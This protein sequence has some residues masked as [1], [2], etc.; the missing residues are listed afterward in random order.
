MKFTI[1]IPA[2]NSSKFINIPLDSLLKQ[3]FK[4]F[5]VLIIDDG[6]TDDLKGSVSKYTS[7]NKNWRVIKK[8]NGNWGSVINYVKHKKL[9]KGDYVTVLD[10]DDFFQ[11]EM[12]EEVSKQNGDIITTSIF[13]L[14]NG[15][16]KKLSV[17]FQKSGPVKKERSFT[18]ISTPHGKFYN[19]D[20]FYSMID[21]KEG[22]S[23]QDTV[24]YHDMA[25]KAKSHYYIN[26]QLATWWDDRDGNSSTAAWDRKRADIWIETCERI[27]TLENSHPESKSWIYMYL[28][29]MNKNY[30]GETKKLVINKKGAKFKW[31]PLGSR[32]IMSLYFKM[33]TK[34]YTNNK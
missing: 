22:I 34:K 8:K 4:D 32:T 9:A 14:N 12:L 11:P 23:Y 5:E 21:L 25:N 2:Y 28:W 20:L 26:K 17:F 29:F 13:V 31:L 1:I 19:K 15:H 7:L 33:K 10:S 30:K 16:Y 6:S 18:P 24:M 27:L 3:T